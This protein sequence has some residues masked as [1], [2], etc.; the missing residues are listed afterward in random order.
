MKSLLTSLLILGFMGWLSTA[1]QAATGGLTHH[2]TGTVN[3]TG[4]FDGTIK[5]EKLAFPD[6]RHSLVTVGVL[7]GVATLPNGQTRELRNVPFAVPTA[8]SAGSSTTDVAP[9]VACEVLTLNVGAIHLD[10]LGLVV[11]IAPINVNVDAIPGGGLLGNLLCSLTGLL[12]GGP[13][14]QL[15]MV[16]NEINRLLAAL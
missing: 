5:I 9:Q 2:V 15:L 12:S 16:V 14:A 7:N 1:S 4:S 3:G 13:F 8:F 10:L 11:D 6:T